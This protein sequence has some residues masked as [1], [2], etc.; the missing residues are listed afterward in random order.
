MEQDTGIISRKR[1]LPL[2]QSDGPDKQSGQRETQAL[3]PHLERMKWKDAWSFLTLWTML[4]CLLIYK[5]NCKRQLCI[6]SLR[7]KYNSTVRVCMWMCVSVYMHVCMWMNVCMCLSVYV[8]YLCVY[9]CGSMHICVYVLCICVYKCTCTFVWCV[10]VYVSMYVYMHVRLC[11]YVKYIWVYVHNV[12]V[13]KCVYMSV[14]ICVC[15][16]MC[17]CV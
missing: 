15:L 16:Y 9:E 10:L 8:Y 17:K 12:C 3:H 7:Y 14:C 2:S 13:W 6:F 4:V 11:M 1:H 5:N